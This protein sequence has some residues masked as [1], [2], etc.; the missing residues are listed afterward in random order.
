M[1][2]QGLKGDTRA[3]ETPRVKKIAA[4]V[5][6]RRGAGA[7]PQDIYSCNRQAY[8]LSIIKAQTTGEDPSIKKVETYLLCHSGPHNS[9][10][11]CLIG[12]HG[13]VSCLTGR[14]A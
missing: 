11:G 5:A 7:V 14:N 2:V 10:I 9:S 12:A 13:E 8:K 1:L 6:S 4:Q 3:H